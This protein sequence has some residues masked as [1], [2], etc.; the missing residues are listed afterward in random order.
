MIETTLRAV[1]DG[2]GRVERV[3]GLRLVG[4]EPLARWSPP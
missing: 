1:P 3:A 2:C 4:P